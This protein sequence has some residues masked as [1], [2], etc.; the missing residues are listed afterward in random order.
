M[1][2]DDALARTLAGECLIYGAA[3]PCPSHRPDAEV[4]VPCRSTRAIARALTAAR[5]ETRE[6]C[7]A[8]V[9]SPGLVEAG[10]TVPPKLVRFVHDVLA[11]AATAIRA[12]GRAECA[13]G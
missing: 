8:L 2:T 10:P 3:M 6:A 11:A 12:Q 13:R 1:L 9:E 5:A 4:C 7:A